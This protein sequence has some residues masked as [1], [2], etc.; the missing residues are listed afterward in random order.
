MVNS[1]GKSEVSS[2]ISSSPP[3]SMQCG[4]KVALA[5]RVQPQ[6][7]QVVVAGFKWLESGCCV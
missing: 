3:L 7:A 5:G 2:S 1:V 4:Q 6:S